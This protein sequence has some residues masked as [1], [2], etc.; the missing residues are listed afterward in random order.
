MVKFY[1]AGY[2]NRE[3]VGERREN[4]GGKEMGG[5]KQG[6]E[7]R[8]NGETAFTSHAIHLNVVICICNNTSM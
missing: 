2:R 8:W 4:G 6:R 5:M 1:V 3:E 7:E